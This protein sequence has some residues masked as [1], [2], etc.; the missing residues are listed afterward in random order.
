MII[1]NSS[2]RCKQLNTSKNINLSS[3]LDC[4]N[5]IEG[6]CKDINEDSVKCLLKLDHLD[7]VCKFNLVA[8]LNKDK[9]YLYERKIQRVLAIS[10]LCAIYISILLILSI[11]CLFKSI[12]FYIVQASLK[13][14]FI[15][16]NYQINQNTNN[17]VTLNMMNKDMLISI[18]YH[19]S[20]FEF[21]T[22]SLNLIVCSSIKHRND[23]FNLILGNIHSL[24]HDNNHDKIIYSINKQNIT[25]R[26]YHQV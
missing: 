24:Y 11:W 20:I 6:Y 17:F 4:N 2:I 9:K 10:I 21:R 26:Q 12:K 16:E 7:H 22:S 19:K 8:Y 1:C 5:D 13:H 14:L 18:T 23:L 25:Y 3:N 15:T